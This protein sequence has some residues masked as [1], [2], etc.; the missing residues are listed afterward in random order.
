MESVF[1]FASYEGDNGC[2]CHETRKKCIVLSCKKPLNNAHDK[3]RLA[4][5]ILLKTQEYSQ[6]LTH[7]VAKKTTLLEKYHYTF[8]LVFNREK[9]LSIK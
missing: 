6:A 3:P 4:S 5:R 8:F 1:F 7:N 9:N 2:D